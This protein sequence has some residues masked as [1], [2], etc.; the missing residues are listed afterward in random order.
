M[1]WTLDL[2]SGLPEIRDIT[3]AIHPEDTQAPRLDLRHTDKVRFTA[4]GVERADSVLAGL[5]AI[6]CSAD[7]WVLVH[8]VARPCVPISDIRRLI[9]EATLDAVGGLLALPVRDTLKEA[10]DDGRHVSR[11]VPRE[12]IWQA[13]TPQ[14]FR[15]GLLRQALESAAAKNLAVTDESSAIELSG[16][17]P[18]LV[19]GSPQNIKITYPEDLALVEHFLGLK[20]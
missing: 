2:L 18:R 10:G 20:P 15:Y 16:L 4:G 1:Q 7:D 3:V 19:R 13:Q 17:H 6:S 14:L 9:A 8:D 12:H 5:Q 11:T